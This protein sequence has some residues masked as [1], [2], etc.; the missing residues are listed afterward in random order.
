MFEIPAGQSEPVID[1][2]TIAQDATASLAKV[3]I[4]GTNQRV[5]NHLSEMR[6][7]VLEGEG[8]ME[9]DGVI[10]SLRPGVEVVVPAGTAYQDRGRMALLAY[11]VPPFNQSSVEVVSAQS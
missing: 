11:A 2:R 4:N 9:V 3:I 1:T 8:Q 6:Y 7:F 10:H 5:I